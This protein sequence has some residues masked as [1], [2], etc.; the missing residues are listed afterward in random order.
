MQAGELAKSLLSA[1]KL[2]PG[3]AVWTKHKPYCGMKVGGFPP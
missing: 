3:Q 2:G 1:V